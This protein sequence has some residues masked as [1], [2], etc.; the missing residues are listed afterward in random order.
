MTE[1][2][3]GA[4]PAPASADG[5]DWPPGTVATYPDGAPVLVLWA[6]DPYHRRVLPL[7]RLDGALLPPGHEVDSTEVATID[8]EPSDWSLA[9]P[10][11]IAMVWAAGRIGELENRYHRAEADHQARINEIATA[12][13]DEADRR[14]WCNEFDELMEEHGLPRRQ[15]RYRVTVQR[16]YL[17]TVEVTVDADGGSDEAYDIA[18]EEYAEDIDRQIRRQIE[19]GHYDSESSYHTE[20]ITA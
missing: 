3:N 13:Q 17:A 18:I 12:L 5:D 11:G 19:D 2:L 15:R 7:H 9:D 16:V 20:R 10:M 1:T 4:P 8:L 14:G 6:T